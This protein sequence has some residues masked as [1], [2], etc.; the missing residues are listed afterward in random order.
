MTQSTQKWTNKNL[1]KAA[2]KIW[3]SM[4][5]LSKFLNSFFSNLVKLDV[6][7][8][9]KDNDS[10]KYN[11]QQLN[12]AYVYLCKGKIFY[13]FYP[14][15]NFFSGLFIQRSSSVGVITQDRSFKN[16]PAVN[17]NQIFE[18]LCAIWYRLCNL[19][20]VKNTHGGM[21]L[22]AKLKAGAF[23]YIFKLYKWYQI[24]Q[25]I[26]VT[27]AVVIVISYSIYISFCFLEQNVFWIN[28]QNSKENTCARQ[29]F[30][31]FG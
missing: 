19:K 6:F 13:N 25:N 16:K 5:C 27:K 9:N 26:T 17:N 21:L 8:Q 11:R 12:I 3:K 24:V 14:S 22:L 2:F 10:L 30:G 23:F 1:R 31:L 20:N 18:T 29:Y 15:W 7:S 28:S 4:V